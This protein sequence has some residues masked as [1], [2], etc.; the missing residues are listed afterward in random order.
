MTPG[1]L[2]H[3]QTGRD[4]TVLRTRLAWECLGIPPEE[5]V[6]VAE[7]KEVWASY[8]DPEPDKTN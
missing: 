8:G 6:E 7:E 4:L 3:V 2:G 5:L 1:C